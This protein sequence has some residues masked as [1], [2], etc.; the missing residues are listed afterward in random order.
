MTIKKVG[1]TERNRSGDKRGV[2][3]VWPL[4]GGGIIW[5]LEGQPFIKLGITM[6]KSWGKIR[7]LRE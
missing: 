4:R 5:L 6:P 7:E 2:L 1:V 3:R